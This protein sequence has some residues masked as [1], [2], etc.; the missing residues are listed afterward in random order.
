VELTLSGEIV[1]DGHR[2]YRTLVERFGSITT[3]N[4]IVSTTECSYQFVP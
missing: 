3:T 2:V 1:C 4:R